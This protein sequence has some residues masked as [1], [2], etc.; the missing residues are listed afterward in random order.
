MGLKDLS[1]PSEMVKTSGGDLALRGLCLE[2]VIQLVNSH[3]AVVE[4]MFNGAMEI[5]SPEED[6]G[7]TEILSQIRSM[8]IAGK[9]IKEAPLVAAHVI[10]LGAGD[11]DKESIEIARKLPVTV[12]VECLD[13]IGTMTF[14]AEGG[15]KKFLETVIRVAQGTTTL[16]KDARA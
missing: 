10:A 6:I 7:E 15:A 14:V 11:G 13:K 9:L 1:F 16:I 4:K 8:D 12:Q 2:D 5:E 3:K